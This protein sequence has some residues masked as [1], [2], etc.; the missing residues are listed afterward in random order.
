MQYSNNM[1]TN[2]LFY[3]HFSA[4]PKVKIHVLIIKHLQVYFKKVTKLGKTSKSKKPT[5][6]FR[7]VGP[8]CVFLQNFIGRQQRCFPH[9]SPHHFCGV[10]LST[11]ASLL[12]NSSASPLEKVNGGSSR[13]VLVPEQP[14][15]TCCSLTRRVRT[16]L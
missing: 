10:L 16:S 3:S 9:S 14:V 6:R 5:P 15:N 2:S 11:L 1:G 13:R 4:S 8:K 12:T 7:S